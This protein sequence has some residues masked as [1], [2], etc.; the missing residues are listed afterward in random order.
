MYSDITV[1][2]NPFEF[3]IAPSHSGQHIAAGHRF[4]R[5]HRLLTQPPSV[6][7]C[8][9]R[10]LDGSTPPQRTHSHTTATA[11]RRVRTA[12]AA[13]VAPMRTRHQ[14][15]R[16][17]TRRQYGASTRAI[18]RSKPRKIVNLRSRVGNLR[19]SRRRID[20]RHRNS[21]S[22]DAARHKLQSTRSAQLAFPGSQESRDSTDVSTPISSF[23][24]SKRQKNKTLQIL[25][26]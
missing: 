24:K 8:G 12:T 13:T 26:F 14:K 7:S 16:R 6:N 2:R 22:K 20:S 15:P 10:H 11:L 9:E 23:R 1:T 4:R 3:Q 17:L 21:S 19:S 5:W 18:L 25:V